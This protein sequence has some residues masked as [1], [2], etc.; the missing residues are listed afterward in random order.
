MKK[1]LGA[2]EDIELLEENQAT[3]I[4]SINNEKLSLES[5]I[6]KKNEVLKE[7][8]LR[9]SEVAELNKFREA[10]LDEIEV[11][12][13][14]KKEANDELNKVNIKFDEL[15]NTFAEIEKQK[16]DELVLME[17]KH[18]EK[19]SQLIGQ[20][21]ALE[22]EIKK[23]LAEKSGV[24]LEI[25]LVEDRNNDLETTNKQR[26]KNKDDLERQSLELQKT[27]EDRLTDIEYWR[28]EKERLTSDIEELSAKKKSLKESVGLILTEKVSV[29]KEI[30]D[31]KT[32][33]EL[34]QIELNKLEKERFATTKIREDLTKK[35]EFI[36]KVYE[37]ASV[38][39]PS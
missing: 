7:I 20:C 2:I 31:I 30:V 11:V 27:H 6:A 18:R 23:L 8:D 36:K 24:L 26:L 14:N 5:V 12:K 10:L 37:R 38:Q 22:K 13:K 19:E 34:S 3:L 29:E 17:N 9:S 28:T 39:F 16:N 25:D 35:E 21:D 4:T 33:R 15:N 1:R 32:A